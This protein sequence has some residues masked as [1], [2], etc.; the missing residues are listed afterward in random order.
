MK[1]FITPRSL[2]KND[3]KPFEM[4]KEN[5]WDIVMN[6][7]GRIMTEE[8]M[9]ENIREYDAVILGVD[10]MT[11]KVLKNADKLKVI[12][13]Y[14]VGL[15]N[16]DL[17]M[18]EQKGISVYRTVGANANAVADYA[19]GLLLDVAR[20]IT[21]IDR[22]CRKGNWNKIT[23]NEMWGKTIGIVGLGAIGKGVAKRARGFNMEILA[24]DPY[25]DKTFAAEN[26]V[27]YVDLD[28]LLKSSDFISL[29][30]PLTEETR[31]LISYDQFNMM[32][33]NAVIA[34][35][36]RGAIINETALYYALKNCRILGAGIDVFD[37]EPPKSADFTS[38]DNIVIGSHCAASSVEAV[39]N[40]SVIS[41]Q[42]LLNHF[43]Y[44]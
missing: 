36:A 21:F 2:G 33:K 9:A 19:F 27:T 40:M 16:I 39:D 34:N 43:N 7:F 13:R 5:N 30:L 23:T 32:K 17:T 44:K 15:D 14:G 4:L 12:S 6:P 18:A 29:H 38:L 3:Q 41:V 28:Y 10:P 35:T 42:N 24:Y 8:E 20:K 26:N 25:V 1:V 22:E 31:E 37:E 11:N